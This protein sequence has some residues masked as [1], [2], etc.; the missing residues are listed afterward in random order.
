MARR[1]R[2]GSRTSVKNGRATLIVPIEAIT[3]ADGEQMRFRGMKQWFRP[4]GAFP[5]PAPDVGSGVSI[6]LDRFAWDL[7]LSDIGHSTDVHDGGPF[8]DAARS[9]GGVDVYVVDGVDPRRSKP[10]E[11][12]AAASTGRMLAGTVATYEVDALEP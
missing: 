9:H 8:L 12:E 6:V 2:P 3:D 4:V 7:H 1:R 5:V 11:L 10:D